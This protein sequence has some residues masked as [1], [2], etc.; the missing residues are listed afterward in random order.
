MSARWV[1]ATVRARAAGRRRL[2]SAQVRALAASPSLGEA[3][4]RLSSGP[5][6]HDVHTGQSLRQAQHGV[7]ATF[8]W[9]Q[10]VLAGWLGP[11]GGEAMRVLAGWA[12][13]ANVDALLAT[14]SGDSDVAP[15]YELGTLATAW[16][17]LATAG[18]RAELRESLARSA[19]GDPGS[20][21]QRDIQAAM[22]LTWCSRVSSSVPE[23]ADWAAGAA[24]LVTAH[25]LMD[26]LS[27]PSPAFAGQVARA[28]GPRAVACTSL[29]EL[30]EAVPSS[31][32]WVLAD[33]VG[34]DDLWRA[35]SAWWRRL[36][37]DG[38][39]LARSPGFDIVPVVGVIALLAVD[40]W[41]VRAALE[42][43][44]RGGRPMEVFDAVV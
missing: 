28:L 24:A 13:I 15:A 11:G 1:A 10:R 12:E 44:D 43:A 3:L 21:D 41:R 42:L 9:G 20:E 18:N 8:L 4:G 34:P 31:A 23:T 40:A 38:A 37:I 7:S 6:G 5:Y 16:P 39:R 17:H 33:V 25:E 19:W 35:E 27:R 32:R 22:R 29:D 30:R 26:P 14:Y 36:E 2:G